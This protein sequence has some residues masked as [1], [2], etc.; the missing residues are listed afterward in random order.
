[1]TIKNAVNEEMVD[2]V[3]ICDS[4]I[5]AHN[6]SRCGSKIENESLT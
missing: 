1:M 2:A 6:I 4:R 3:S 5:D